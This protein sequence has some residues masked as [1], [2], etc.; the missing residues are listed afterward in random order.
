MRFY[1]RTSEST[2]VSVGPLGLLLL[3]PVYAMVAALWVAALLAYLL[4]KLI[5]FAAQEIS[6]ARAVRA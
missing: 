2:G 1:F 5:V 3:L 4:F 6:R